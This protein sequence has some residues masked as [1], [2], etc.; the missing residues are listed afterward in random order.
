M[1]DAEITWLH[2][3]VEFNH[4]KASLVKA[5]LPDELVYFP[6]KP[7]HELYPIGKLDWLC[8]RGNVIAGCPVTLAAVGVHSVFIADTHNRHSQQV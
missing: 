1:Q 5:N 2:G 3:R 6:S 7:S 4:A 8:P